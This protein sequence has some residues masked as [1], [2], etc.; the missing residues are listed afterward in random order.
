MRTFS[1]KRRRGRFL[2]ELL[3]PALEGA[4]AIPAVDDVAVRIGQ[5]LDLDVPRPVDELLEVDAGVLERG[6]GLGS[7]R[8]ERGCQ[9]RLIAADPHPLAAAAGG[10]LDQHG[11]SDAARKRHRLAF[12]GDHPSEPGTQATLAAAAIFL[13]SVFRPILRI[14]SCGGP[15]NSKQ[16]NGRPRQSRGSRSGTHSR[17]DRL[18]V[19]HLGGGDDPRSVQVAVGALALAD[20]DR[21]VGLRQIGGIA[22]GLRI[23]RHDL[24]SSSLQARITRS[25][26]SPRL[27]TRIR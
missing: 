20:A 12:A 3:M 22:V 6:L 25:A 13:A 15:M 23:D 21:A 8:L 5:D 24:D 10:R 26:I 16:L 7:G 9:G 17:M 11:V 14:A 1:G 18:D 2:D 4:I 19:G 27:A